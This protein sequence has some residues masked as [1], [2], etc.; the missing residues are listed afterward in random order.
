[1]REAGPLSLSEELAS[2]LE[3][4]GLDPLL[5]GAAAL[6]AHGYFRSTEDVDFAVAVPPAEFKKLF[7]RL[8][9]SGFEGHLM[10][11]D[12]AD[13]L[14]G[15]MTFEAEGSRPVQVVNFDNSPAGGFPALVRSAEQRAERREGLP[16]RLVSAEHL[17]LFKL[18]AGGTKSKLD[19]TE[20]M[21]RVQLDMD[22]LRNEARQF[23]MDGKLERLLSSLDE[24]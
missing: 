19:I 1:M 3:S 22:L 9:G 7:E 15:V 18:Y 2:E 5:I 24:D 10:Q 8:S 6:A 23:R 12:A 13:P 14:G 21:T 4:A 11:S 16:G 17:V 20:L